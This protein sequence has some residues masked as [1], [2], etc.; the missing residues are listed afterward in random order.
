MECDI[1]SVISCVQMGFSL[2]SK[3]W[4]KRQSEQDTNN[5]YE[6]N[7]FEHLYS[8]DQ[9]FLLYVLAKQTGRLIHIQEV[10]T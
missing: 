4:N 1:F 7:Y 5:C 8:E 3:F 10:P 2:D 9:S 6:S